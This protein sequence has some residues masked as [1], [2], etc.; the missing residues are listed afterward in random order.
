MTEEVLE[1]LFEPFF[2]RRSDGTGTGLGLSIT[3]RIVTQHGGKLTARSDG[4][5]RG[6][7][8]QFE[9]PVDAAN[10]N[11]KASAGSG[12]SAGSLGTFQNDRA[13]FNTTAESVSTLIRP[14]A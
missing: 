1:H 7:T 11:G 13:R 9:L 4:P 2:T 5:N 12:N 3:H 6:S 8:L 10:A 14:A